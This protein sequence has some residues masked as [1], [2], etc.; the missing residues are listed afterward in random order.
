MEVVSL[1]EL[2]AATGNFSSEQRLGRGAFGDVYAGTLAGCA[3]AVK[4]LRLDGSQVVLSCVTRVLSAAAWMVALMVSTKARKWD[5]TMAA[6]EVVSTDV[7]TA[8]WWA[9]ETGDQ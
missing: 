2:R 3:V 8:V 4:R 1:S 5:G 6:S 7:M 9:G